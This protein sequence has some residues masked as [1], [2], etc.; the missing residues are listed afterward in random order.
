MD[1]EHSVQAFLDPNHCRRR[2]RCESEIG[3]SDFQGLDLSRRFLHGPA[4]TSTVWAFLVK[5]TPNRPTSGWP[6]T[7]SGILR[8]GILRDETITDIFASLFRMSRTDRSAKRHA[9]AP[10]LSRG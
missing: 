8:G 5:L 4:D 1:C 7:R 10:L 6:V 9:L 2:G 3:C